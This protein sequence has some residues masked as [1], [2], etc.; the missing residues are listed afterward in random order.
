MD[1]GLLTLVS[2]V[3]QQL[4]TVAAAEPLLWHLSPHCLLLGQAATGTNTLAFADA[5]RAEPTTSRSGRQVS[6]QAY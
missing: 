5:L 1:V 3:T 2:N 6:S 4:H